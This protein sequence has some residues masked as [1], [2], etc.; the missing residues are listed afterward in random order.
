[1]SLIRSIVI[2][3]LS[4]VPPHQDSRPIGARNSPVM[5]KFGL[6]ST[7]RASD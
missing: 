1:M 2:A 4:G 7:G 3:D 5:G 6:F